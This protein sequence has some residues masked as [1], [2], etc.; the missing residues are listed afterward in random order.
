[1]EAKEFLTALRAMPAHADNGGIALNTS[2]ASEGTATVDARADSTA[3]G[4]QER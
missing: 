2:I 4:R 1:M 3:C